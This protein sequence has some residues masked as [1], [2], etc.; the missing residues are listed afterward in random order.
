ME[1]QLGFLTLKS[2]VLLSLSVI[3]RCL[4]MIHRPFRMFSINMD[5]AYAMVL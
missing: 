2:S 1:V 3:Y 4:K 5:I